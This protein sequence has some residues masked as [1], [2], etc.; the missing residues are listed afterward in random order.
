MHDAPLVVPPQAGLHGGRQRCCD[1]FQEIVHI[2]D[3]ELHCFVDYVETF[4]V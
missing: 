2:D 1:G 4:F 3:E